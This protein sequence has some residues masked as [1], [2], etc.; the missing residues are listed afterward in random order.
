MSIP[1]DT[2]V[3]VRQAPFTIPALDPAYNYKTIIILLTDCM[4]TD[5]RWNPFVSIGNS[6]VDIRAPL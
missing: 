4:N 1:R 6:A 5:D 3:G 2:F